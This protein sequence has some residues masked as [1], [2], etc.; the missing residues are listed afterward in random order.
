[1]GELPD[2]GAV[3]CVC[4]DPGVWPLEGVRPSTLLLGEGTTTCGV[5]CWTTGLGVGVGVVVGVETGVGVGVGV[6]LGEVLG[7]VE[8]GFVLFE[9]SGWW[10]I[11]VGAFDSGLVR[12]GVAAYE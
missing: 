8:R 1:M 2:G 11:V 3:V 12:G 7:V 5:G 4:P 6:G 9:V 10:V